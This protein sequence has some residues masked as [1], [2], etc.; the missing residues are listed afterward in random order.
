MQ[1]VMPK[2]LQNHALKLA[3]EGHQGITKTKWLLK[4]KV[5]WPQMNSQIEEEIRGCIPCLSVSSGDNPEPLVMSEMKEPWD[6][7]HIDMYGPLPTGEYILGII[8][9]C[10]RWPEIHIM[11]ST[12]S[13]VIIQK[14]NKSF[15]SLGYPSEIVTDNAPN[16]KSVDVKDFC[17]IYG[18]QHRKIGP[19]WPKANSEIERFY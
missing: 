9:G 10:T 17:E 14:L 2:C 3:H 8:D 4:E 13:A 6:T 16:L 15:T 1:I 11:N 12:T 7:V 5:W 18:I 19:Y